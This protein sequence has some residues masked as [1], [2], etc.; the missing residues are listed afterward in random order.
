MH[1]EPDKY[2]FGTAGMQEALERHTLAD[3]KFQREILDSNKALRYAFKELSH[4]MRWMVKQQT[5]K[6][7]PPYVRNNGD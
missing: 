4:F 6:E 3:S 2:G 1:L 5:G 7:P